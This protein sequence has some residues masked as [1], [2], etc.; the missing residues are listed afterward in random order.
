MLP[1]SAPTDSLYKFISLFGLAIFILASY[2]SGK[3]LEASVSNK[4]QIEAIKKDIRLA[5]A[6]KG[7]DSGF[8]ANNNSVEQLPRDLDAIIT[9]ISN[10]H[11]S[12]NDQLVFDGEIRKLKAQEE[13]LGIRIVEYVT[14]LLAGI[15]LIATGFVLWYKRDQLLKDMLLKADLAKKQPVK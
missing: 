7:T 15:I 12:L 10:S 2:K 3:A 9:M 13:S 8:V 6:N 1:L 14:T 11:L 5:F 4:V